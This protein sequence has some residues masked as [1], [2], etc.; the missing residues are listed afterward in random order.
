MLDVTLSVITLSDFHC[1]NENRKNLDVTGVCAN[2]TIWMDR[3]YT[4]ANGDDERTNSST[5]AIYKTRCL[6]HYYVQAQ[7]V[8]PTAAPLTSTR[9]SA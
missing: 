1:T 4:H 7:V 3:D 8:N 2:C 5:P 9:P 6:K